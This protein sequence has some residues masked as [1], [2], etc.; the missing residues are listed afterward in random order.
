MSVLD[1]LK[2]LMVKIAHCSRDDITPETQL[3]DVQADSL[4]WLQI[5]IGIESACGVEIDIERM[6][7][8]VTIGDFVKYIE[9]LVNQS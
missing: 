7:E 8:F 4:H 3:K 2:E 9:S 1:E 6:K 5:I